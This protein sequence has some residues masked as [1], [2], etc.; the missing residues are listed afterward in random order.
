VLR[1]DDTGE[2]LSESVE[3]LRWCAL[4][5]AGER[6]RANSGPLTVMVAGRS[7]VRVRPSAGCL[8]GGHVIRLLREAV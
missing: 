8:A 2:W 4:V 3:R 1:W 6:L 5:R 7:S